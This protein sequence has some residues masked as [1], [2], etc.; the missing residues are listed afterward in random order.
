M[1]DRNLDHLLD[2]WM[3]LGPTVAP[4]RVVE[5]VRLEA[6][7]TRQQASLFGWPPRRILAM[8]TTGK[9]LIAAAAVVA[10]AYLGYTYLASPNIGDA[11]PEPTPSPT[12]EVIGDLRTARGGLAPGTYAIDDVEPFRITMTVPAGWERNLVPA[13]VWTATELKAGVAVFTVDDLFADVCDETQG[14]AEIGPSVEDLVEALGN[15]PGLAIDARSDVT[16]SEYPGVLVELSSSDPGCAEGSEA[17]LLTTLPGFVDRPHPGEEDQTN[18]WYILNVDGQRL[19][20]QAVVPFGLPE[21]IA[22]EVEEIVESIRI[23]AP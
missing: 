14:W 13:M 21:R 5:A 3:D 16:V 18:R 12:A 19:V 23:T 22:G 11:A 9:L 1:T 8:N 17:L 4:A 15:V 6:R 10:A 2:A 20:I 7:A